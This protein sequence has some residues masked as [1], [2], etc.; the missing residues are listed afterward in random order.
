MIS[1]VL[2]D[3]TT[4]ASFQPCLKRA[5]QETSAEEECRRYVQTA[6]SALKALKAL[7]ESSASTMAPLPQ[8]LPSRL[9]ELQTLITQ[10]S[11]VQ[12]TTS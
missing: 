6:E 11:T 7:T 8:W 3:D 10:I 4:H 9:L 5:R 12:P 1:C 2:C